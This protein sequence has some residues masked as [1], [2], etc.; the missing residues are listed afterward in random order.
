MSKNW[1]EMEYLRLL[2]NILNNGSKRQDRT[3]VG[4]YSLFGTQLR[5]S[6]KDNV[7]PMLT[8]KKMFA[9]GIVEELLFFLRGET[10]TTKLEAKGVNIWK[11]NTT[12]EFLDKRGM[13]DYPTGD[14]GKGYGFEWR[15]FGGRITSNKYDASRP[16]P[17]NRY[18]DG[19]DQ[20]TQVIH[21]LKTN[22]TDRRIIISAWNPKDLP[23]AALPPCHMMVQ[24]YADGEQLSAQFYMRS[25]DSFLGLPFNILSYAILTRIVAET[26][27]MQPKELVFIGGDTHIYNNHTGPVLEQLSREPFE[28]PTMTIDKPLSSV[29]DIENLQMSDFKFD[30]YQCHPAIKAEMAV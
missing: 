28:F 16:A 23:E 10:D 27:G 8:T 3:G 18:A 24:F 20:L 26:V 9:K 30:N 2:D 17:M 22:P 25:V 6:L 5:F 1:E 4:T 7:V 15:N 19:V 29:R 12:R 14:M 11:G 21:T 13:H